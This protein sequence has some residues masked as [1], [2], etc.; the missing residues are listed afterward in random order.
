MKTKSLI[1][2]VIFVTVLYV[3]S[4]KLFVMKCVQGNAVTKPFYVSESTVDDPG[5]FF[6]EI[7]K[8]NNIQ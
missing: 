6:I 2:C 5:Y 1:L 7:D 4:A 3:C 8:N